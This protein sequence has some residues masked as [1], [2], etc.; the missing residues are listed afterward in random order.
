MGINI[1]LNGL[2]YHF[3][4]LDKLIDIFDQYADR[5]GN[6]KKENAVLYDDELEVAK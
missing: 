5:V 4:D 1:I 3:D 2:A 6:T